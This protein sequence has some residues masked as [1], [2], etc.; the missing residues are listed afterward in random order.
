M[1]VTYAQNMSLFVSWCQNEPS[2]R[3][4]KIPIF[5]AMKDSIYPYFCQFGAHIDPYLPKCSP[6]L[7]F[8]STILA[9]CWISNILHCTT[10]R[11][12]FS[13][14][15]PLI[16][17]F[18]GCQKSCQK[19]VKNITSSAQMVQYFWTNY[20]KKLVRFD[21]S[22]LAATLGIASD[23]PYQNMNLRSTLPS[24]PWVYLPLSNLA[25]SN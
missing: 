12:V 7:R 16:R 5:L 10:M 15:F 25:R 22:N 11:W 9:N 19:P 4:P 13:V 23:W 24:T 21:I 2:D 6:V 8:G 14:H 1:L 20:R 3:P 17:S 18:E